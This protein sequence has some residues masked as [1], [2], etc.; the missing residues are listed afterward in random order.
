[1]PSAGEKSTA[2]VRVWRYNID[3]EKEGKRP[4][5]REEERRDRQAEALRANLQRRKQQMRERETAGQRDGGDS[6][7]DSGAGP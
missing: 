6:G 7:D 4:R 3:M 5:S 1:M 2:S